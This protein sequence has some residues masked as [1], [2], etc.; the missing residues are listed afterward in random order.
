MLAAT[1]GEHGRW[2]VP[3]GTVRPVLVVVVTPGVD[4]AAHM[5]QTGEPMLRQALVAQP[6]VE[7]LD[8]GV[9]HRKYSD[10]CVQ[11]GG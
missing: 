7:A 2:H 9:L 11:G 3:Q 1:R 6:A 8:V 5:A 4:H 10:F